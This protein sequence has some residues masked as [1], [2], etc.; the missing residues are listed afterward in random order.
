MQQVR[1]LIPLRPGKRSC[2]R[3]QHGAIMIMAVVMLGVAVI[4]WQQ[5]ASLSQLLMTQQSFDQATAAAAL[6]AAQW[7]ARI[8]NT[9]AMLNRTEMA[10]QVAMAHLMT[11]ASAWE[12]R[13]RMSAQSDR[14][15]PPPS[16]IGSFFGKKY[17]DA[18]TS[19]AKGNDVNAMRDL[20]K[21]FEQH[22]ALLKGS[23]LQARHD[24]RKQ[25]AGRTKLVVHEILRRN[26]ADGLWA[27]PQVSVEVQNPG[28]LPARV[29]ALQ[30]HDRWQSWTDAVMFRH[31][32]LANRRDFKFADW[33][34]YPM[35]P[36]YK[37]VLVRAGETVIK[38]DGNWS[39]EDTQAFHKVMP[40]PKYCYFREY[41]MGWADLTVKP[42][43]RPRMTSPDN[44]ELE[45]QV[46][47]V[48]ENFSKVTFRGFVTSLGNA[49]WSLIYPYNNG[50]SRA[51]SFLDSVQWK[52][53]SYPVPYELEHKDHDAVVTVNARIRLS[54]L[55]QSE[56]RVRLAQQGLL[57][58]QRPGWPVYLRASAAATIEYDRFDGKA[59]S[60]NER[61]SLLQPFWLARQV[62]V[63]EP[64]VRPW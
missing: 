38:A 33:P 62:P 24:L 4:A 61:I 15:D 10:H 12:M 63:N 50:L 40:L 28:G 35:C 31:E 6:G 54:A 49:A 20:K 17:E 25:L 8:M 27:D 37:H 60:A 51:K 64:G 9:H 14:R 2:M 44:D 52:R 58:A 19:A 45:R 13:R 16:L 26:L 53:T 56:W 29:R 55:D 32:Y 48:P 43:G 21:A 11:L 36:W 18:F 41:P 30:D 7:H 1:R 47:N 42:V 3:H 57:D 22:D 23:L 34:F 5:R 46:I 59:V 39:V